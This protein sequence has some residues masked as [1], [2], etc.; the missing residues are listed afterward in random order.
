M[1]TA[2]KN[3]RQKRF[4]DAAQY[5]AEIR[6]VLPGYDTLHQLVPALSRALPANSRILVVGCGTGSE[7]LHLAEALPHA[8]ID[9]LEPASPMAQTAEQC[10]RLAGLT[11][12][13]AVHCRSVADHND[14]Q[15]YDI[16]VCL[17]VSHFVPDNG[18]RL[19]FFMQLS[20]LLRRDGFLILADI[21][22]DG[23]GN[24]ILHP[25]YLSWSASQGVSQQRIGLLEARLKHS[26][27]SLNSARFRALAEQAGLNIETEFFRALNV[28]GTLLRKQF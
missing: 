25:T 19:H 12:R 22:D 1:N 21:A 3:D 7:L 2:L 28:V 24:E 9:A 27:A 13:V 20:E 26:F 11:D 8:R 5:E 23:A 4:L 15:A 17:L 14:E 16:V 10:V 18:E 6:T